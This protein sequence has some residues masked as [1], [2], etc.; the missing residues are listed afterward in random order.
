MVRFVRIELRPSGLGLL[1]STLA[2]LRLPADSAAPA[3]CSS[4]S[5]RLIAEMY[6]SIEAA[7]MFVLVDWPV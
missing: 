5:S 6:A 7:M 4:A 2:R 1:G 3:Q